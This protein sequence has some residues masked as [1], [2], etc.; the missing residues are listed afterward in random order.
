MKTDYLKTIESLKNSELIAPGDKCAVCL[1]KTESES[2]GVTTTMITSEVDYV[3]AA[4]NDEV[5]LFDIDKKTGQYLNN[6]CIF[7][8]ENLVY[9]KKNKNWIWASKGLFGGRY[10]GIR[11]DFIGNFNHTYL[12]P[13]KVHGYEQKAAAYELYDFI[14]EVYNAHHDLQKQLY[15]ESK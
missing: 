11:A 9:E 15:K 10:I 1:F 2:N 6:C 14:K 7:K 3:M 8:K 5:K 12:L 13:K 4:N